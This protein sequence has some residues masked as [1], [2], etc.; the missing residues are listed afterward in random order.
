M[1]LVEGET[2][3]DLLRERERLDLDEARAFVRDVARGLADC[4]RV[5]VIHRDVKPHNL[6]LTAAARRWKLVDFGI[7]KLPDATRTTG[8][9]V[10]GTPAYMAPEQLRGADVDCRADLYSLCLVLYRVL[11]GR[12]A[13]A[14][15][16]PTRPLPS[17]PYTIDDLPFDLR[18][19][20][21]IG[22]ASDPEARFSTAIELQVAFETAFEQRL[23]ARLRARAER[24]TSDFRAAR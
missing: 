20:L 5:G 16:R 17:D 7:A 12:P 10:V 2:L 6:V 22:L 9:L 1:E 4:H 19:V 24:L 23:D 18:R 21:R 11:A 13:F 3:A 15:T 14:Y 8:S